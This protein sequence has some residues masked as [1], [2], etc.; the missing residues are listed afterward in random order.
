MSIVLY[1]VY[2]RTIFRI[3]R[4]SLYPYTSAIMGNNNNVKEKKELHGPCE[5]TSMT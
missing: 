3:F 4:V 1:I 2:N 5:S